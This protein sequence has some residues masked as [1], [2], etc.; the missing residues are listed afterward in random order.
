MVRDYDSS[1]RQEAARR[2]REAI[3]AAAFKLHGQGIFDLESLA[4]E[5]DVSVATVRKHFPNREVLFEACTGYGLHL[6]PMPD[7]AALAARADARDRLATAVHQA[8]AFHESLLGQVWG[9]FKLEDESPV[10]ASTLRQ[11]EGAGEALAETVVTAWPDLG[12]R[13]GRLRGLV[14]GMLSP[15]TY[16]GLRVHGGLSPDEAVGYATELLLSALEAGDGRAEREAA[17][18]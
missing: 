2:T 12:D 6:A 8:Y 7:F 15:L 11:V 5:A 18:H 17:Y 10:L 3:L 13:A 9:A 16:R 14:T 1:R 4:R